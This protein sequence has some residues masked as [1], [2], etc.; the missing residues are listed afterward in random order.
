MVELPLVSTH[1]QKNIEA[2]NNSFMKATNSV[3][4]EMC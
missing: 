4:K 1:T 2:W 3:V